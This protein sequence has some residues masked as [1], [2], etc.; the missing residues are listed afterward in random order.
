MKKTIEMMKA[1]LMLFVVAAMTMPMTSCS[2]DDKGG[3][4]SQTILCDG[5][6]KPVSAF[7]YNVISG[8]LYVGLY[9]ADNYILVIKVL[10]EN[11]GKTIRMDKLTTAD[12][13]DYFDYYNLSDYD[14]NWYCDNSD[15][16]T[17]EY[18]DGWL[19]ESGSTM[20]VE[21]SGE[22]RISVTANIIFKGHKNIIKDDGKTHTIKVNFNGLATYN[23]N[24]ANE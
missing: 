8:D 1:A 22:D 6:E 3:A 11:V 12:D 18:P 13:Y 19:A 20:K 5:K 17:N 24:L 4:P 14:D 21:R 9:F 16:F 23:P 15:E 10:G 7:E 2:D